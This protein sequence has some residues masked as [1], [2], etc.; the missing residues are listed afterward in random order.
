[1]AFASFRIVPGA[2]L[3]RRI[4]PRILRADPNIQ[5]AAGTGT[6]GRST[7]VPPAKPGEPKF[8]SDRPETEAM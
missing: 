1:L 3:L 6:A 8:P 4:Q 2:D 5:T 7:A